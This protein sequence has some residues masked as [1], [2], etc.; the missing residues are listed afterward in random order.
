MINHAIRVT[1]RNTIILDQYIYPASHTANAG[2]NNPATQPPMGARL[3]LKSSVDLSNLSP[4]YR[5]GDEGLWPD[6]GR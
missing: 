4:H 2:N 5:P 1:L 3:R 6:R